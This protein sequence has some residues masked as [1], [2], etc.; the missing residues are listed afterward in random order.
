MS[1][2]LHDRTGEP[3]CASATDSCG[4]SKAARHERMIPDHHN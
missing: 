3:A 2:L 4:A 1:G